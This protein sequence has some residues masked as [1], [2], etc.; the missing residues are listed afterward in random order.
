M[1]FTSPEFVVFF[2]ILFFL[3]WMA[4]RSGVRSQNLLLLAGSCFFYAWWKW[5][6][7][8][9]LI[10]SAGVTYFVGILIDKSSTLFKKKLWL[11][12]GLA[13]V[14][15]SLFVFKYYDF[16]I[17]FLVELLS[18]CHIRLSLSTLKL[19]L[20][21]GISFYSFRLIGY[22]LDIY[23]ER[24]RPLH[25][26]VV[27]FNYVIFFPSIV[28][29]PID[30]A[31][32]LVP[33]L[34]TARSFKY[35]MAVDGLRQ[36]LWGLF[37][38]AVIANGLSPYVDKVFDHPQACS[39]STLLLGAFLYAFQLY[40]DFSGY[41]DMA[42]GIAKMLGLN[43]SRNFDFPFFSQNIAEFWRK[44][45]ISLTSWFTDYLFT[46]LS[47]S[48]RRW[49][50]YGLI[51]SVLINFIIIGIWHGPNWTFV[52]F[53]FLHGCYMIPLILKGRLTKKRKIS[54]SNKLPSVQEISRMLGTFLLVMLTWVIFRAN[55]LT[56]GVKYLTGIFSR[57]LF[58]I[59][60]I[61]VP[62]YLWI[63]IALLIV[64]DWLGRDQEYS[65]AAVQWK[66]PI[67]WA[68]Y[69]CLL[70]AIFYLSGHEE[71]FIY[72]HF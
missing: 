63:L 20:P 66:R 65:I 64:F 58:K 8:S 32:L 35:E 57:S 61:E 9:L 26:W 15:G 50:N 44:W 48:F 71:Q 49:G 46:P 37:K 1:L 69:Y 47:M 14:L 36:I 31:K 3:Y 56:L 28:S 67:R 10:C 40:A 24:S 38:K 29:G 4:G 30:R 72:F 17:Q 11:T 13:L 12:I 23:Y 6:F 43:I 42:I 7:L 18:V 55:D 68:F 27:F 21:L 70:I 59:P 25:D 19:I 2:I 45:N 16:F 5:Q 22:L 62:Y 41:S 33:Q 51:L 52:L 60:A 53:G 54:K 34:S 39:G